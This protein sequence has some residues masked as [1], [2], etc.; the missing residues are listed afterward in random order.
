MDIRL[1]IYLVFGNILVGVLL[2][3][4]PDGIGK[5]AL[6][7]FLALADIFTLYYIVSGSGKGE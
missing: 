2:L 6:I 5:Y 3:T 4:A 7:T 1:L